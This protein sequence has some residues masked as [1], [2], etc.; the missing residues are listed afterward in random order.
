[1]FSTLML[2]SQSRFGAIVA[3]LELISRTADVHLDKLT[4]TPEQARPPVAE[5]S[6]ALS[7]AMANRGVMAASS[8]SDR[9]APRSHSV[10]VQPWGSPA[11]HQTRAILSSLFSFIRVQSCTL[12]FSLPQSA[13]AQDSFRSTAS[14]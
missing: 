3:P 12:S 4:P 11:Q 10:C 6:K 5:I 2:W 13:F 8:D 14:M 1:M 7:S 9:C